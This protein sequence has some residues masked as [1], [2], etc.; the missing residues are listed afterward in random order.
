VTTAVTLLCVVGLLV[1]L[2]RW[3]L[4]DPGYESALKAIL[5]VVPLLGFAVFLVL[6][7]RVR[8]VVDDTGVTQHWI[9]RSYRVPLAEITGIEADNGAGRWFLR[10]YCGE[11]T[12]EIMPCFPA[13]L[14]IGGG[15]PPRALIALRLNLEHSGD[16]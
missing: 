10:L 8:T 3:F 5:F 1:T 4:N 6:F 2:V 9:R 13:L 11:R 7:W 16:G 12:F 14:G 15:A